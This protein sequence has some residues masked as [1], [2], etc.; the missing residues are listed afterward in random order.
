M[1]LTVL[2]ALVTAQKAQTIHLLKLENLI[3]IEPGYVFLIREVIK[4]R[5]ARINAPNICSSS[6]KDPT[7]CVVRTLDEY[8][9]YLH[10][11]IN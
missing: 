2:L 9:F 10:W 4:E 8:I 7:L 5:S 3:K 6:Y 1:K 11:G